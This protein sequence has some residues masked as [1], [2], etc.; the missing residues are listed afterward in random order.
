MSKCAVGKCRLELCLVFMLRI[1]EFAKYCS[2]L[3]DTNVSKES[4]HCDISGKMFNS[5]N[6]FLQDFLLPCPVIIL[7]AFFFLHSKYLSTMGGIFPE[8]Y[9][10]G[11]YISFR[12]CI[13]G[14]NNLLE[15]LEVSRIIIYLFIVY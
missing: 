14:T 6:K 13:I 9:S 8:Y 7:I 3:F 15:V 2:L 5:L 11:H 4:I 1:S 10:M 12:P